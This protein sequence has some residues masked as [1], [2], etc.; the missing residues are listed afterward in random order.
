MNH[1][2]E[3]DSGT[4]IPRAEH[5]HNGYYAGD[6]SVVPF[7]QPDLHQLLRATAYAA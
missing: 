2:I 4:V 5:P 6:F 7:E 3:E 1:F